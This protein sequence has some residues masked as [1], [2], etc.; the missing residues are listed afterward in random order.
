[1]MGL[2][3][4][5]DYQIRRRR[6]LG[7]AGVSGLRRMVRVPVYQKTIGIVDETCLPRDMKSGWIERSTQD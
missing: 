7:K 5:L 3:G 4:L 2:W 6:G 1:M